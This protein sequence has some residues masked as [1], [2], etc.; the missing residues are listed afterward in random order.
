MEYLVLSYIHEIL[1]PILFVKELI[2]NMKLGDL[3][4]KSYLFYFIL[5][6]FYFSINL[7]QLLLKIYDFFIKKI[8]DNAIHLN[9]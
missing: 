3:C 1:S 5:L 4:E 9:Y 6:C 7:V 2:Y 8:L